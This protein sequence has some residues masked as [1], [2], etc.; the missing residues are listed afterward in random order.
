MYCIPWPRNRHNLLPGSM[1]SDAAGSRDLQSD[2]N[3]DVAVEQLATWNGSRTDQDTFEAVASVEECT[4]DGAEEGVEASVYAHSNP[5]AVGRE[6]VRASVDEKELHD[7]TE[8]DSYGHVVEN[9]FR[10]ATLEVAEVFELGAEEVRNNHFALD[11]IPCHWNYI[12]CPPQ[13]PRSVTGLFYG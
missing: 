9:N 3:Q 13:F 5:T 6:E 7:K 2:N 12:H 4:P 8:A 10:A 1:V 11:I